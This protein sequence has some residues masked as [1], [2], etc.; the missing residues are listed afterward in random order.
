M[1]DAGRKPLGLIQRGGNPADGVVDLMAK[2]IK[3]VAVLILRNPRGQIAIGGAIQNGGDLGQPQLRAPPQKQADRQS[4]QKRDPADPDQRFHQH[5]IKDRKLAHVLTNNQPAIPGRATQKQPGF[6]RVSATKQAVR[7]QIVIQKGAAPAKKRRVLFIRTQ[8]DHPFQPDELRCVGVECAVGD[9]GTDH[10]EPR[11][12]P[13]VDTP[14]NGVAHLENGINRR[15]DDRD[16]EQRRQQQRL[17]Q[18]RHAPQPFGQAKKRRQH[19]RPREW[20]G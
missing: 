15:A 11:F 17:P 16:P 10:F 5:V 3:I 13:V 18:R 8:I 7:C 6:V 1:C 12:Q 19:S 20:C 14:V 4:H 2:L 9:V